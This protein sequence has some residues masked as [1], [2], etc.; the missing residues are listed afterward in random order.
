MIG[1][2]EIILGLGLWLSAGGISW[3][4][5]EK[6][7]GKPADLTE[8]GRKIEWAGKIAPK[9]RAGMWLLVCTELAGCGLLIPGTE[10]A[11]LGG[12]AIIAGWSIIAG[13]QQMVKTLGYV[14]AGLAAAKISTGLFLSWLVVWVLS[15]TVW[16]TYGDIPGIGLNPVG[17]LGAWLLRTNKEI[18][19]WKKEAEAG[20]AGILAKYGSGLQ[21]EVVREGKLYNCPACETEMEEIKITLNSGEKIIMDQCSECGSVR[22]DQ[23]DQTLVAAAILKPNK[24]EKKTD[25]Y[26]CPRC[27]ETMKTWK[28][29][30]SLPQARRLRC[31]YCHGFFVVASS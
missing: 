5:Q 8:A 15:E 25:N 28:C 27:R 2:A 10:K 14:L 3:M 13:K 18:A 16:I 19:R 29:A 17:G 31:N 12:L 1:G 22:Y 7:T 21:T 24:K 23:A 20:I 11:I 30:L 9:F 26:N 6:K 4:V